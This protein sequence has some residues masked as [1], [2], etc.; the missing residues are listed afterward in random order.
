MDNFK[1]Y[2]V[3]REDRGRILLSIK[4]ILHE[5]EEILFA[6]IFGSFIDK[7]MPFFRDIDIG[8]YVDEKEVSFKDTINYT[9][10]LSLKIERE[11]KKY[12]VD[13]V[14]LNNAPLSLAFRATQG[15]VLFIRNE[16]LWTDFVTKIWSMYHDHAITSRQVLQDIIKE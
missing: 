5:Q 9:I 15:E 4:S 8:I 7:E 12:P 11:I 14:I 13:I 1:T 3:N 6:Y 2:S 10:A 16:D